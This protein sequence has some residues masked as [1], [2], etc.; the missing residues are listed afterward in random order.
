MADTPAHH[1]Q[2]T[3]DPGITGAVAPELCFPPTGIGRRRMEHPAM[4]MPMPETAVDKN[5]GFVFWQDDIRPSWITPVIDAVTETTG[6][7][8]LAP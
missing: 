7:Q 8:C 1:R 2:C 5:D 3:G 6:K 4:V